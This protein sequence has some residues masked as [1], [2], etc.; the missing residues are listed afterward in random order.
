MTSVATPDLRAQIGRIEAEV[1]E[2]ATAWKAMARC[3]APRNVKAIHDAI[4]AGDLQ[5]G[6]QVVVSFVGSTGLRLPHLFVDSG[7]RYDLRCLANLR[8]HVVV[9]QGV[10]ATR[11]I[12]D[13]SLM[14][15]PYPNLIDFDRQVVASIVEGPAGLKLWPR[16]RGSESWAA[17][18]G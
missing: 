5:E 16:Q 14:T 4:D 1:P 15:L 7:K 13:V 3:P 2:I 18:F 11:V 9:R 17:L 8:A 12:E 10:D 6:D